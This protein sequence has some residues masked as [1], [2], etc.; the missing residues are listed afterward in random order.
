MRLHS[1]LT[2]IIN[3]YVLSLL[4]KFLSIQ[5]IFCL[6]FE[7]LNCKCLNCLQKTWSFEYFQCFDYFQILIKFSFSYCSQLTSVVSLIQKH[8]TFYYLHFYLTN[9]LFHLHLLI[10]N[11]II[12]RLLSPK[13]CKN[14]CYQQL[15]FIK[16]LTFTLSLFTAQHPVMLSDPEWLYKLVCYFRRLSP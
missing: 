13:C 6:N 7:V 1:H 4:I 3:R 14:H 15:L 2:G 5:T 11:L 12:L 8:C 10:A 16:K 9:N